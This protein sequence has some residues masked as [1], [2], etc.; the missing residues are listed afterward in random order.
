MYNSDSYQRCAHLHLSFT[1]SMFCLLEGYFLRS[2]SVGGLCLPEEGSDGD[3]VEKDWT[4]PR[5]KEKGWCGACGIS[6]GKNETALEE[7]TEFQE[8][9]KETLHASSFKFTECPT[10]VWKPH[11][12]ERTHR[13]SRMVWAGFSAFV[14]PFLLPM[15]QFISVPLLKFVH[16]AEL[17][18][19]FTWR[20]HI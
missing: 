12:G 14:P 4:L 10:A 5:R 3:T 8:K 13:Q 9:K 11:A 20:W 7:E 18:A 1:V 6:A 17:A 15:E 2:T 16:L 19:S